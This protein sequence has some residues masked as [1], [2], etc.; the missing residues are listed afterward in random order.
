[1]VMVEEWFFLEAKLVIESF[2]SQLTG[3][4]GWVTAEREEWKARLQVI[5][6]W[7]MLWLDEANFELIDIRGSRKLLVKGPT[8]GPHRE[9]VF[10]FTLSAMMPCTTYS[11]QIPSTI[12]ISWL[13]P[14]SLWGWIH[15]HWQRLKPLSATYSRD[16][17]LC[18]HSQF[19]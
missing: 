9:R 5:G 12:C 18:R 19:V 17:C 10:T 1:M 6:K 14:G 8:K 2:C 7:R 11:N 4:H 15:Y 13:R 3:I 16:I